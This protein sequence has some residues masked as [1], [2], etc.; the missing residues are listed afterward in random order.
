MEL[1]FATKIEVSIN[2]IHWL[3][4]R[5]NGRVFI[6]FEHTADVGRVIFIFILYHF[7]EERRPVFL[8]EFYKKA[9]W[10]SFKCINA[11]AF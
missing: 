1:F 8:I 3:L 9:V 10:S 4:A 5:W 2:K 11:K 6:R 7:F